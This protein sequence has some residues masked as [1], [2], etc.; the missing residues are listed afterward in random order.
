MYSI[1]FRHG[2]STLYVRWSVLSLLLLLLLLQLLFLLLCFFLISSRFCFG[3]WLSLF[4]AVPLVIGLLI[5]QWLSCCSLFF[6]FG[7]V[8]LLFILHLLFALHPSHLRC[9]ACTHTHLFTP[10]RYTTRIAPSTCP[11]HFDFCIRLALSLFL[12]QCITIWCPRLFLLVLGWHLVAFTR[13]ETTLCLL[14]LLRTFLPCDDACYN[15]H[16]VHRLSALEAVPTVLSLLRVCC[17]SFSGYVRALYSVSAVS[18]RL[19]APR[20]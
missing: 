20:T 10:F 16:S 19:F 8:F 15:P 11:L 12:P 13:N 9:I 18:L 2:K 17:V 4:T 14:L 6:L 7:C 5:L 1:I 3:C